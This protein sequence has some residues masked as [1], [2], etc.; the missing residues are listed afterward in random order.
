MSSIK[1]LIRDIIEESMTN[2]YDPNMIEEQL[3]CWDGYERVP[4]TKSG[5]KGSCRKIVV[6]EELLEED[7][8]YGHIDFKPPSSVAKEAEKGLEYRK[9]AG[10][11]GGLSSTQAKKEGVGSGVQ[12]ASNL[13]NGSNLSPKTVRRMKAFFD[14]HEKNSKIDAKYKSEPWKDRGYVAWLLWGGDAG[15]S[16]ANKIVRQMDT[17]EEELY[18]FDEVKSISTSRST[19]Y[20]TIYRNPSPR[21]LVALKKEYPFCR[22]GVLNDD[23]YVWRGN[24][25]HDTV[26]DIINEKEGTDEWWDYKLMF[27][28]DRWSTLEGYEGR[29]AKDKK[30]LKRLLMTFPRVSEIIYADDDGYIWRDNE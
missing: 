12:R 29:L 26:I 20:I 6:K 25:L 18:H 22:I 14:R 24:V 10:G 19:K 13:K 9:K 28:F 15:R 3:K 23:L 30:V 5:E 27:E 8:K 4:G 2:V 17:V 16:W 7:D 1:K 11:R 21:E